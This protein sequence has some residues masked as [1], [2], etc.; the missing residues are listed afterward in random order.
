MQE[1]ASGLGLGWDRSFFV[2][3]DCVGPWS[4]RPRCSLPFR[5]ALGLRAFSLYLSYLW[6]PHTHLF[7]IDHPA[8]QSLP[9]CQ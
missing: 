1:R 3:E 6:T 8:I 5:L 9:N 2:G 7:R 4:D